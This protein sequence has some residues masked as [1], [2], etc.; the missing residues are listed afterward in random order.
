MNHKKNAV[1]ILAAGQ[2]TRMKSELPKVLHEV[3]GVPVLADVIHCVKEAG[4]R[5]ISV[6]VGYQRERFRSLLIGSQAIVQ[7]K[8]LGTGH[9]VMQA[10]AHF[11]RFEGEILVMPGDVPCMR[12]ETIRRLMDEHRKSGAKATVLTA[13]VEH[14]AGYGHIIR[15]NGKVVGIREELDATENEKQIPEVN[16]GIY[17]FHAR[18]LFEVLNSI[19]ENA[20]KKEY[21]LTDVIEEL[22]RAG[23]PVSSF[24]CEDEREMQGI[25][26]R[27]H[28]A[29]ANKIL[30]EREINRHQEAGVTV[31]SPE[32]TFIATD[33]EIGNDTV[34][35]PFTWIEPDVKIGKKCIVGPFAKI[36]SKSQIGNGCIVGSF[37]EVVRSKVGDGTYVKHLSY[38]GD[39][40]LGNKVNVGA[41]TVVANY[42]GKNKNK[43]IVRDGAFLGCNT[44]LIAPTQV[45][46]AAKTGAGA[47]V[48]AHHFVPDGE[49]VVGVPANVIKQSNKKKK[50]QK[51]K[52]RRS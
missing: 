11:S 24:R 13:E 15:D 41:G 2:G 14:P 40:E 6:V 35:H 32:Q 46:R 16:S 3:A 36:R 51:N 39:A 25:N 4:I 21:Y 37:V 28:L 49:T 18:T 29:A 50:I 34:I 1:L 10:K 47:V 8:Q 5:N 7:E 43:T 20:K 33:V 22:V 19:K 42:D 38:L 17:M 30:N 52:F 27:A 44:V 23:H 48:R 45:G 12:P 31:V 26:T 9:A